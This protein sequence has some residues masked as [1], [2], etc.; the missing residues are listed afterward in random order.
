MLKKYSQKPYKKTNIFWMNYRPNY[1]IDV[2]FGI[3]KEM[4]IKRSMIWRGY[5]VHTRDE[6]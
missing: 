3:G 6:K 5:I 1:T 4:A 2:N